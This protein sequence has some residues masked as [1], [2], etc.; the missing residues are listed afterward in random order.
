MK[1]IMLTLEK[2]YVTIIRGTPLMVQACII[3]YRLCHCEGF[4][5]GY[6]RHA[7]Q[8]GLVAVCSALITVILNSAAYLAGVLRGGID[9]VEQGQKEAAF[10]LGFTPWQSIAGVVYPQAI[11]NS[12]PS[13]VNELINNIKGTS[14]LTVIGLESLC[15]PLHRLREKP[16]V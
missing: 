16:A 4:D 12:L 10:S 11:R 3:Y 1:Y 7:S 9:S 15:S 14:L 8:S 5:A 13:I 2:L 6:V